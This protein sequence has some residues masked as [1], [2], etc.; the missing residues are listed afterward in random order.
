MCFIK[1][2]VHNVITYSFILATFCLLLAASHPKTV[3]GVRCSNF[4]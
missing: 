4:D 3:G 2:Y 1:L